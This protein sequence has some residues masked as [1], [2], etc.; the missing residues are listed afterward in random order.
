MAH[1]E[2]RQAPV[3]APEPIDHTTNNG[4]RVEWVCHTIGRGLVE[5]GGARL[6]CSFGWSPFGAMLEA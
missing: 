4:Y 3:P 2:L 1:G 6:V 5:G